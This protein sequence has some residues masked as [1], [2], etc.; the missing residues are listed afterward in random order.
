M[1]GRR[2]DSRTPGASG[3]PARG[4]SGGACRRNHGHRTRR[5]PDPD[6]EAHR[7]ERDVRAG[8]ADPARRHQLELP[9]LGRGHD[10]RRPG[11]G[12]PRLGPRRQRVHRPADGLWPGD[13]R[14]RGRAG[15]RL[16]ERADAPGR[17]LLAHLGGRGPGDGAPVRAE[18]LAEEGA[19]DGL[20]HR[21]D[22]ARDARGPGRDGADEDR[23]VRGPVPRRPRLCAR[24]R[25]PE[26][27]PDGRARVRREP[28]RARLGPGHPGGRHEDDHSGPL[29]RARRPAPDLRARGGRHRGDHHRAS[30]RQ[31]PGHPPPARVPRGDPG[32]H[33][34]V[35]R[36]PDLR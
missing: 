27:E 13:P 23:Q 30:A 14:P 34:G 21:G 16:R 33:P 31:C 7:P 29:Q 2:C 6:P 26:P 11:Q 19:D 17:Q 15:R 28:G 3:A 1:I 9:G 35:R 24:E 4:P 18:R 5:P 20:G 8:E 10:L 36:A 22:D 32:P 12:L 25:H